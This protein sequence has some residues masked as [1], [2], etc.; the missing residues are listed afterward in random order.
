MPINSGVCKWQKATFQSLH[1]KFENL[2][3]EGDYTE[4]PRTTWDTPIHRHSDS[5]IASKISHNVESD[6]GNPRFE[7]LLHEF[8]IRT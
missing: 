6:L 7:V 1:A 5:G 4:C 2:M 3:A 8:A